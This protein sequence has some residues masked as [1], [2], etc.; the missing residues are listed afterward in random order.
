MKRSSRDAECDAALE[1]GEDEAG[2]EGLAR[3]RGVF[4]SLG[5]DKKIWSVVRALSTQRYGC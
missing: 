3:A 2:T 5:A 4:N 1:G